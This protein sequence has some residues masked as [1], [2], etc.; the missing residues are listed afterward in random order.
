MAQ[1]ED[2]LKRTL[3]GFAVLLTTATEMVRAKGTKPALLDAYDD[4]S[5]QIIDG[6][7]GNGIPDD[8]L[9]GIHKALARLRLAFEE[10]KS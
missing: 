5:D 10:Q 8:Q 4:A 7:R 3:A 9:Q 1:N 2:K 6:L